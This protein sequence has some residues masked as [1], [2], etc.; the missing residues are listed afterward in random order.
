MSTLKTHEKVIFERIFDRGGYVLNFSDK[1]FSEFFR[2]HGISIDEQKYQ[3]NGSSK[4]KRLR[5]FWEIE[6]DVLVGK[7]IEALMQYAEAIEKVNPEDKRK[8]VAVIDRLLGRHTTQESAAQSEDEFL[9]RD[10][11]KI[12]LAKLNAESDLRVVLEQRIAEIKIA[13]QY[14]APL[15]V[16]FLCGS[17][18]EGLLLDVA[19][20]NIQ[21]FN[22]AKSAPKTKEG[23]T[24][25]LHEWTLNDF[26]N[27]A[28]EA[29]LLSLDV[30]KHSHALRDFRNYIHPR[31]Q[32]L[33]R[34]N[35]DQHTA[36]IS[37]H[38]LQAAIAD[39]CKQR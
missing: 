28:N 8:A 33:E 15:S 3:F 1:T 19:S 20:K 32:I 13:L 39:L 9:K 27:V 6:P 21:T 23:K 17:A 18:L 26:I 12:D 7:V 10:F 2:E 36:K 25:Q 30:K 37:W 16:V 34:F 22:L 38:V 29:G 4:M 14:N 35:P 11:Q 31:Q 5:A 24:R